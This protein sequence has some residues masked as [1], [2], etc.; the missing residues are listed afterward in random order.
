MMPQLRWQ[1]SPSEIEI[2]VPHR[3]LF[4]RDRAREFGMPLLHE[5]AHKA[6][7]LRVESASREDLD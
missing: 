3:P 2:A 5:Q 6:A 1:S 7:S 4:R